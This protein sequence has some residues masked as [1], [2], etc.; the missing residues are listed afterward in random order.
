MHVTRESLYRDIYNVLTNYQN[1]PRSF[2]SFWNNSNKELPNHQVL[3]AIFDYKMIEGISYERVG[4]GQL[5]GVVRDI[6]YLS[7]NGLRFI[8]YYDNFSKSDIDILSL[9]SDNSGL[10]EYY[11]LKDKHS[12]LKNFLTTILFIVITAL[13]TVFINNYFSR[14]YQT[15]NQSGQPAIQLSQHYVIDHHSEQI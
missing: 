15:D 7:S 3:Q 4:S 12:T 14:D 10:V 2:T 9:L 8:K 11:A 1:D 5:R 13:V 6:N